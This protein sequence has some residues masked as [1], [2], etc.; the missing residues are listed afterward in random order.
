MGRV[1]G[2][3]EVPVDLLIAGGFLLFDPGEDVVLTFPKITELFLEPV[4]GCLAL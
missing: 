4:A 3:A 2:F 1:A